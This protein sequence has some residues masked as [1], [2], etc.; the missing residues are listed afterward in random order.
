[1]P[2]KRPPQKRPASPP[3]EGR[4]RRPAKRPLS[5]TP[6]KTA[7]KRK[8]PAGRGPRGHRRPYGARRP[9]GAAAP[10]RRRRAYHLILNLLAGNDQTMPLRLA[11]RLERQLK[12]AGW[13]CVMHSAASWDEYVQAVTAAIRAR[14]YAVVVFGGDGSVRRA[15]AQ[16]ARVKGLLGIIPCGRYN[17]IFRSLYGHGNAENALDIIRS[18]FQ[19]RIDAGLANGTFFLGHL[20]TGLVPVVIK[21]LGSDK[22]PRLAMTWSKIAARAADDTMPRTTVMKVDSYTFEAQP[23]ILQV[24]LL[25]YLM[26]LRF[27]P[28]AA[29]ADGRLV[30]IYDRDGNR[31]SVSH[32]IK[33]LKKDRYQ[34]SDTVRLIRGERISISPAG[35]RSW[36]MDGDEVTFTGSEISISVLHRILRIFSH[37]PQND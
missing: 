26:T 14:P 36:L 25:P 27:A 4:G 5:K 22:P 13:N 31:D 6:E 28:P 7:S 34:Y 9:R 32:Y 16:I 33:D 12:R 1:M 24:H 3:S 37:A 19:T 30:L 21:R 8:P 20:V 18:G 11:R 17:N 2:E 29:P 10:D 23:L 15:A 35:G